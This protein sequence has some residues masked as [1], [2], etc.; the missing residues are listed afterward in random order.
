[1]SGFTT[2]I[3]GIIMG[4]RSGRT[5]NLGIRMAWCCRDD[6]RPSINLLP[7]SVLWGRKRT[8]KRWL[9]REAPV[10]LRMINNSGAFGHDQRKRKM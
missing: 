10:A 4:L 3:T 5:N 9:C 2:I 6:N 8:T 1:M 7:R